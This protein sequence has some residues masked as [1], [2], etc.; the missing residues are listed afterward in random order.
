MIA[1][2]NISV[3]A[4]KWM[5]AFF[6]LAIIPGVFFTQTIFS[7]NVDNL[8][9]YNRVGNW[10]YDVDGPTFPTH[11]AQWFTYSPVPTYA[12][13]FYADINVSPMA[14]AGH[15][16]TITCAMENTPVASDPSEVSLVFTQ[17]FQLVHF[18]RINTV[19]PALPWNT[20]G[21]SGDKRIYANAQGYIAFNGTP[22][23][24]AKTSPSRSQL[25]I[26]TRRRSK[27]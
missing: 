11:D 23:L 2:R 1:Q 3:T 9:S 6:V 12:F 4:G 24:Y 5:L 7:F 22:K 15:V 17:P 10:V 14:T 8:E 19:N 27:A 13:H 26:P 16:T 21:Q 25:P 20:P 18:Q